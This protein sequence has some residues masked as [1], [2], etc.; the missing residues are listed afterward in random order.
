MDENNVRTLDFGREP[1]PLMPEDIFE[2]DGATGF[3]PEELA[4][5]EPQF[6]TPEEVWADTPGATIVTGDFGAGEDPGNPP[7]TSVSLQDSRP[8]FWVEIP[9]LG[10]EA[11]LDVDTALSLFDT[12]GAAINEL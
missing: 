11:P 4:A 1:A 2:G 9:S 7:L 6:T 8:F 10:I 12:L 3:T 5:A